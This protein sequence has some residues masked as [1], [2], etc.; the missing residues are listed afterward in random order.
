MAG[1]TKP[2]VYLVMFQE[3]PSSATTLHF[4]YY[5]ETKD[6]VPSKRSS[7]SVLTSIHWENLDD[8]SESAGQLMEKLLL[9]N[10]VPEDKRVCPPGSAGSGGVL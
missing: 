1:D 8:M 5:A 10:N 3:F 7:A 6:K 9:T 4:E 2:Y